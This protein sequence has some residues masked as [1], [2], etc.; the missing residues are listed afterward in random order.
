MRCSPRVGV[1]SRRGRL[2]TLALL[3][4]LSAPP[5]AEALP[6]NRAQIHLSNGNQ[7]IHQLVV[8]DDLYVGVSG[9]PPEAPL[10]IDLRDGFGQV[11]ASRVAFTDPFGAL[12]PLSL[13]ARSGVVGCDPGVIVSPAS[14]QFRD[15]DQAEAFLHGAVFS[16]V[17][18]RAA[19]QQPLATVPLPLVADPT[20][21][22]FF[23]ADGSGCPRGKITTIETLYLGGR[24]LDS[25][26][27]GWTV[28]L[29]E[30]A[31]PDAGSPL[32][33]V[34]PDYAQVPQQFKS[35]SVYLL[36]LLWVYGVAGRYGAVIRD[37]FD[38]TPKLLP[39]D[40]WLGDEAWSKKIFNTSPHGIT[41]QDW[42]CSP[43]VNAPDRR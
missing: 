13:W 39:G 24:F 41:I 37:G 28:F 31:R 17:V 40:L 4:A 25:K 32:H 3:V 33:D 9:A 8:G 6:A 16:V 7:S 2:G 18:R 43:C 14:Y 11:V 21:G 34:R 36:E 1:P 42:P 5:A 12:P 19:A 29:M 27:G 15:F 22:R 38:P 30:G 20:V 23:F 26:T 10:H 35:D